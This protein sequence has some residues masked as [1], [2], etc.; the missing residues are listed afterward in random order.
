MENIKKNYRTLA[1]M[2][3]K[4]KIVNTENFLEFIYVGQ[5]ELAKCKGYDGP[6]LGCLE[7]KCKGKEAT[8]YEREIVRWFES[9][10]KRLGGFKE[11]I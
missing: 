11:A 3:E 4:I 7:V 1:E 6:L 5:H 9:Y 10:L 2:E 8:R